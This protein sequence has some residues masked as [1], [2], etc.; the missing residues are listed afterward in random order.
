MCDKLALSTSLDEIFDLLGLSPTPSETE[1]EDPVEV[2]EVCIVLE[3]SKPA[4]GLGR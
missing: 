4:N 2:V 1:V 3:G